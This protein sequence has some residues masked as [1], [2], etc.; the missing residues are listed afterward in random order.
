MRV[1]ARVPI[2]FL[3]LFV[4]MAS[5]VKIPTECQI[6]PGLLIPHFSCI[7]L[8]DD[9]VIGSDCT[10][11]HGVTIGQKGPMGPA[12]A[13]TIGDRVYIG[14]GAKIL[15]PIIIGSDVIIGANAVVIQPVP[16]HGVAVGIPARVLPKSPSVP[17]QQHVVE[18]QRSGLSDDEAVSTPAALHGTAERV[19]EF[20][21]RLKEQAV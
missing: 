20:A 7:V 3:H 14:A 12:G 19:D 10:L 8:Y 16:D 9:V 18:H 4:E 17:A 1:V 6:G 15:G 5:G 21:A 2:A 13:A 11:L